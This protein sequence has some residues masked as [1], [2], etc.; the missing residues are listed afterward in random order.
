MSVSSPSGASEKPT[1]RFLSHEVAAK[2][3]RIMSDALKLLCD[4]MLDGEGL[5]LSTR[6]SLL[7]LSAALKGLPDGE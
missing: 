1:P 2:Q 7:A 5:S 3:Y 6:T 4:A